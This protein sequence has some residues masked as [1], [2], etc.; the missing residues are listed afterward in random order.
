MGQAELSPIILQREPE[1][2]AELSATRSTPRAALPASSASIL[3]APSLAAG[4]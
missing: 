1:P 4:I 2:L 3:Q